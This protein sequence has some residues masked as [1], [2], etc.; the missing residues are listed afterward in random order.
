MYRVAIVE[1]NPVDSEL[2]LN[3]LKQFEQD[4]DV[5]FQC[6]QFDNASLFLDTYDKNFELILMDIEMPGID[7]MEAAREL[8]KQ[9]PD[10]TLVFIT[11]MTQYAIHGYK[12]DAIDYILKPLNYY[13]FSMKLKK[14][15]RHIRHQENSMIVL[16]LS[17]GIFRISASDIY[18]IE[19][20]GHYLHYHT[21]SSVYNV[22]ST[23]NE[24]EKQ[25]FPYHFFRCSNSYLINA[26]HI[27][28]VDRDSVT[29]GS[30]N[31]SISR[32]KKEKFFR[33]LANYLGGSV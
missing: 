3:L 8:R 32:S 5:S 2:L 11:N 14:A 22:R 25:L 29:I 20:Q 10:V 4:T 7:G 28:A 15:L 13:S 24:A 19:V 9:D 30:V 17:D 23:M 6:T 31:L 33:E 1:D 12:V 26:V 21:A 18:Y 16:Y 27:T